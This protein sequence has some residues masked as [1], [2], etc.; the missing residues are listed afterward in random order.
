MY[1]KF[2]MLDSKLTE[3]RRLKHIG[4]GNMCNIYREYK[5]N[6]GT[7]IDVRINS[8]GKARYAHRTLG[9]SLGETREEDVV[10][11]VEH[12]A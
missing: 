3:A 11:R 9:C 5:R 10:E 6:F 4:A 7:I 8:H 1:I 12:E 2:V